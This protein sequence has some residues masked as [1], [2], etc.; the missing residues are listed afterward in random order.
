MLSLILNHIC[1]C[2]SPISV[3][4]QRAAKQQKMDS[5][6]SQMAKML[7]GMADL[8][9]N[10][11]TKEDMKSVNN[12]LRSIESEQKAFDAHLTKIKRDRAN[13]LLCFPF[14][15]NSALVVPAHHVLFFL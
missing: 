4:E 1:F 2:A 7:E 15:I 8:K 9:K 10:A 13:M 3:G 14:G 12:R 11:A 5:L 6:Q